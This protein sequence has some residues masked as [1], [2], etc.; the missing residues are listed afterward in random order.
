MNN[1]LTSVLVVSPGIDPPD[2]EKEKA[3]ILALQIKER[4]VPHSVSTHSNNR[5]THADKNSN[6]A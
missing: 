5:N 1:A 3:G 2:P 4:D 6:P